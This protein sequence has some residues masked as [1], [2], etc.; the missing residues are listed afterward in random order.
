[1]DGWLPFWFSP[2]ADAFYRRALD[3]GFAR[4]S[5][6]TDADRFEVVCPV[7]V[8]I[9]PDP[10]AA[11]DRIRPMLALY[12]GGMGARGANFHYDVIARLGYE[13]EAARIQEL[14]LAGRRHEAAGSIPLSMVEDVALVGPP[15]KI[16]EE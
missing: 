1:A 13:A 4:R 3:E 16:A 12:V 2:S 11:A 7:P 10:E 14:Y 9:D 6:P 5:A 15:A 8:V